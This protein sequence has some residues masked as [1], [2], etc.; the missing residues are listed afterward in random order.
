[1]GRP[2]CCTRV[3]GLFAGGGATA[4]CRLLAPARGQVLAHEAQRL[5]KD[6]KHGFRLRCIEAS[7]G[8]IRD[9]VSLVRHLCLGLSN[10]LLRHLQQ[11]FTGASWVWSC[12]GRRAS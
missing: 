2:S 3:L 8:E 4:G 10:A 5:L 9:T 6:G 11:Q 1:M 12:T 7:A